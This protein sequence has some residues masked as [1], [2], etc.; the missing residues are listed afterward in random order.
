LGLSICKALVEAH[1]GSITA[2]SGGK[3]QG[4]TFRFELPMRSQGNHSQLPE[5]KVAS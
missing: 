5:S 4:T 3:N 2:R 1:G